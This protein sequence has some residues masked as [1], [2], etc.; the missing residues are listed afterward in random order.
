M[1]T[2]TAHGEMRADPAEVWELW[3]DPSRMGEWLPVSSTTGPL[4]VGAPFTWQA[5]APFVLPVRTTGRVRRLEARRALELELDMRF[6]A[7]P[8]TLKVELT[9]S[10]GAGHTSVAIHHEN[11]PDD[12]LGLFETNGYGHYW[13]QHLESLT[14]C[15]ERRAS[16]HHHGVQVGVYFVGGHPAVGVLVGGVVRN[17]PVH[18]AGLRAGD[19]IQ[20]VD[21][22]PVRSIVEFDAWLDAAT[23]GSTARLSLLRTE[24]SVRIPQHTRHE[25][26]DIN[27]QRNGGADRVRLGSR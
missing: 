8:S 15:A 11:L 26:G 7:A 22:V 12:D 23:P 17:S 14:A 2:V 6:S 3:T 27:G 16:D 13:L 25:G 9:G 1:A 4:R 10:S 5:A 18:H 21:G 19:V 24:L 20:A